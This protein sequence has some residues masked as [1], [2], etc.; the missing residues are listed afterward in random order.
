MR[1][2]HT[3]G[4]GKTES[5]SLAGGQREDLWRK[6]WDSTSKLE[7]K[8]KDPGLPLSSGVPSKASEHS[9][10]EVFIRRISW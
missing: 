1:Q 7:Q 2:E 8:T 5:G 4:L 9:D 10:T 6:E 3:L